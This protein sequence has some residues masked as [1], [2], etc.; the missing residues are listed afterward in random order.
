M[1]EIRKAVAEDFEIIYPLLTQ[2]NSRYVFKKDRKRLFYENWDKSKGYC[3]Y[4]MFD[5]E[6]VVGFLGLLFN[7]RII[8]GEKLPFCNLTNWIVKKE[9]RSKSIFMLLPVLKLKSYTLTDLTPSKK[10]YSLLKK[11]GFQD[12][13][14]HYRFIFPFVNLRNKCHAITFITDKNLLEKKLQ[15]DHLQIFHDHQFDH[16]HHMLIQSSF[17]ECYIV[18]TRMVR[19]T[20]PFLIARI[21][22]FSN[23]GVFQKCIKAI[24]TR[25]CI[26]FRVL[27]VFLDE[28]FLNGQRIF[29]SKKVTLENGALFRSSSLR[30]ED[31]DTLYSELILL[32]L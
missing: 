20:F 3:G 10:V 2:F 24:S 13:E 25:I 15:G 27:T 5:N 7:I 21:H 1:I 30:K 4:V 29:F 11:S 8:R 19:K 9:Y 16:C 32:N 26:Q 6:Q 14:N 23:P 18:M 28:R 17:G 22:Y 31:I 12:L